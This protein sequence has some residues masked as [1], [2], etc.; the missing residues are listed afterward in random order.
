VDP[1]LLT[2]VVDAAN[3]M[4]ARPDGWWRDRAGAAVRLHGQIAALAE[5]GID[6]GE[7]PPEL[8]AELNVPS[9]SGLVYPVFG[10]VLEGRAREAAARLD[11]PS[12]RVH[13]II[14]PGSGDDTIV[15]EVDSAV[16]SGI[17][18]LAVTADRE[19]QQRCVAAGGRVTGPR[20]LLHLL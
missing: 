13:V 2:V 10:L 16:S 17:P 3:V 7:L 18:C 12:P 5:R 8:P 14:A 19:L 11:A 15:G 1:A 9:E 4:G 6:A 20:W